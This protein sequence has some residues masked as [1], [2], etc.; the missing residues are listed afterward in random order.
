[1]MFKNLRLVVYKME[2]K[3]DIQ[4]DITITEIDAITTKNHLDMI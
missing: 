2:G 3:D 4:F 1:M